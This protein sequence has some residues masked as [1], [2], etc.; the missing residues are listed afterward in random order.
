[1]DNLSAGR[2][3]RAS[4]LAR[5]VREFLDEARETYG[6]AVHSSGL[7]PGLQDR[8]RDLAQHT[9]RL[10]NSLRDLKNA[11]SGDLKGRL[12]KMGVDSRSER[13]LTLV[14][15]GLTVI[16]AAIIVNLTIHKAVT[17]PIL[18]INAEL[19]E[20]RER[21]EEANRA[22]SEF[23]ANMSHEIRTPMNGILGMTDL[24]LG[25][26]LTEEQRYYLA[27][28]RSS[29]DDLLRVINDILDFSKIE[30]GKMELESTEFA[31]EEVLIVLLKPLGMRANEKGLELICDIAPDVPGR[32]LGD[33][34]RL[35]Q[36]IVNLIG[37]AVKFT[38]HGEIILKVSR[39]PADGP[40]IPLHF[41]ISDTG[42]GIPRD[43]QTRIFEAFT[44]A[45][46]S[47]TRK[48]GGTGLGLT[49]SNQLVHA[50]GG[51][52]SVESTPGEGSTFSFSASFGRAPMEAGHSRHGLEGHRVLIVDDNA[53]TRGILARMAA[54][55][56]TEVV[57]AADATQARVQIEASVASSRPF[58]AAVLDASLPESSALCQD[59][60]R[61]WSEREL[62]LVLTN[63][64]GSLDAALG[65][66]GHLT[67][68]V[69]EAELWSLLA[70]PHDRLAPPSSL[71]A[72]ELPASQAAHPPL[73]V[74]LAEDNKVNQK[75]CSALLQKAGHTVRIANNGREAILLNAQEQFDVILM[76]VQM[77][78]MGGF[79][80]TERIRQAE[81]PTGQHM[82]I[83]ALTAHAMVGDR[84]KCLAAGMDGYL[85]KP[86]A[87]EELLTALDSIQARR[88]SEFSAP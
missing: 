24:A 29:G 52:L 56:G 59:L 41:T 43:Q 31:L 35:G 3:R 72:A 73:R 25:T 71:P 50:M 13:L 16:L 74:L 4:E 21:A 62:K 64:A 10:E 63:P 22:K 53:S 70:S 82:P 67:K 17:N 36:I 11:S 44:Q 20:A 81:K 2:A 37:N 80:A 27:I 68:P 19:N 8:M 14:V 61:R 42:I 32:L 78:E 58:Q 76:D 18:R 85:S 87:R 40:R 48:Y 26:A 7:S 54:C 66:A 60:R 88:V 12:A 5:D 38:E 69:G 1:M 86:I 84:E 57:L 33:P 75:L 34:G 65:I 49:I 51:R 45:D 55:W 30:A 6:T 46:G 77:P 23:L 28:A 47:T 9:E 15:F 79:E 83:L 39:D